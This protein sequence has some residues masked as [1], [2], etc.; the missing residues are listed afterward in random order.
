V[1]NSEVAHIFG[2]L[3]L[4]G[5]SYALIS[6]MGWDICIYFEQAHLVTLL[7]IKLTIM[8]STQIA[9]HTLMSSGIASFL[10][11]QSMYSKSQRPIY[12]NRDF[13]VVR[14][15]TCNITYRYLPITL[16]L[17]THNLEGCRATKIGMI[18]KGPFT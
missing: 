1:E 9:I 10:P 11:K 3:F 14:R 8:V 2:P 17:H 5:S 4:H 18:L 15:T 13:F 16:H 12:T 6:N 7:G